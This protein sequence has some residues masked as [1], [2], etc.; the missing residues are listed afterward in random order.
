MPKDGSRV[1]RHYY[2]VAKL[3]GIE[4]GKV[5]LVDHESLKDARKHSAVAFRQ[6]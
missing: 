5:A 3:A 1:S 4:T 6:A 2:D